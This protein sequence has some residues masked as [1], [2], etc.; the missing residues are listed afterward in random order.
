[1]KSM[2]NKFKIEKAIEER[3]ISNERHYLIQIKVWGNQE[4]CRLALGKHRIFIGN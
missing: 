4:V 3:D 2:L 1:M